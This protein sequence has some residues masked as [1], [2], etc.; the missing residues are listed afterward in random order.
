M[1]KYK[2]LKILYLISVIIDFMVITPKYY[3]QFEWELNCIWLRE[4]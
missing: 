3:D 1:Y 2:C 4:I